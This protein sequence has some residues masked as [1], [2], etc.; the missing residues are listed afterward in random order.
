MWSGALH[1]KEF[2]TKL[3]SHVQS[4]EAKYG[5]SSRMK[6][7]V[8]LA[9]EELDTPFYFTPSKLAG[10][11]HC[12]SPSLEEVASALLHAGY[13]VSRSHACPGS[14]KTTATRKVV[15][16]VFRSH[17]KLNPVKMENIKE[18]APATALLAKTS[19]F[20]ANFKRHP[21]VSKLSKIK[22][23]RYQQNPTSHWGPG[24]KAG[25]KKRKRDEGDEE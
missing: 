19:S 22:L 2:T 4:E 23:V 8:T 11:F 13:P 14:I 7:M 16:D 3:L 24:A 10:F 12:T 20:E 1:D 17:V 5:T 25:G 9:A 6:G 21:E 15:H 18:G